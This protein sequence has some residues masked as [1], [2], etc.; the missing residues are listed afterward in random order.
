MFEKIYRVFVLILLV[1]LV[2]GV[3]ASLYLTYSENKTNTDLNAARTELC[4]QAIISA[5]IPDMLTNY[6]KDVYNNPSVDNI[7]QQI[8]MANEYQ[9]MAITAQ[10]AILAGCLP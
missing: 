4:R 2:V 8:L 6:H 7:N 9:V 3:G 10:S 1:V 5:N